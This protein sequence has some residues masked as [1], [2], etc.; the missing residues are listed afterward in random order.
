MQGPSGPWL[1]GSN[2][3]RSDGVQGPS[4][5]CFDGSSVGRSGGVMFDGGCVAL[6]DDQ[7][8]TEMDFSDVQ[9]PPGPIVTEVVGDLG[10]VCFDEGLGQVLEQDNEDRRMTIL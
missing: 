5:P 4:G 1:D 9:G 6:S 8:P 3:G 10:R 2:V 7:D